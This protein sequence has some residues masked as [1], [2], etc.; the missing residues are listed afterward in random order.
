MTT[1]PTTTAPI[2]QPPIEQKDKMIG[3]KVNSTNNFIENV[4][5]Y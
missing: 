3:G 4:F 2:T 5:S 1:E